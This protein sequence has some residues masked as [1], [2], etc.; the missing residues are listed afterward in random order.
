MA[1]GLF[2]FVVHPD[3]FDIAVALFVELAQEGLPVGRILTFLGS[4]LHLCLRIV[5][6]LPSCDDDAVHRSVIILVIPVKAGVAGFGFLSQTGV[7]LELETVDLG[8]V[9]SH[10]LAGRE[11]VEGFLVFAPLDHVPG[12]ADHRGLVGLVVGEHLPVDGVSAGKVIQVVQG[13]CVIEGDALEIVLVVLLCQA[14]SLGET[15]RGF[16]LLAHVHVDVCLPPMECRCRRPALLRLVDLEGM[17]DVRK[18]AAVVLLPAEQA[19]PQDECVDVVGGV[20]E[21][22]AHQV[23]GFRLVLFLLEDLIGLLEIVVAVRVLLLGEDFGSHEGQQQ[24]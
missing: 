3:G 2:Q 13:L 11:D 6:T 5:G 7:G 20:A 1:I 24:G 10:L 8:V 23:E 12:K 17:V 4:C 14:V 19:D 21:L 22:L 15:L 18:G 16:A 9:T